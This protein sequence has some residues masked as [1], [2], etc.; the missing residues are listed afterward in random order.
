MLNFA[1]LIIF[2][3]N[4]LRSEP[5]A[6]FCGAKLRFCHYMP[7]SSPVS[8]PELAHGWSDLYTSAPTIGQFNLIKLGY[9]PTLFVP[10]FI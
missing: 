6:S 2:K 9:A 5:G 4:P 3:L 7:Q 1:Q 8:P 10:V